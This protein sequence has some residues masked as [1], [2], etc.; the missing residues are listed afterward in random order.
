VTGECGARWAGLVRTVNGHYY[1]TLSKE[2]VE[3][4]TNRS[5]AKS[6][7]CLKKYGYL[8][9]KVNVTHHINNLGVDVLAGT[10]FTIDSDIVKR[11]FYASA[12]AILCNSFNQ[13]DLLRRYLLDSYCLPVLQ[14]NMS[15]IKLTDMQLLELNT[16]WNMI[17]RIIFN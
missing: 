1:C 12:N 2:L 8:I 17:F 13:N 15:V 16:C 11:K 10:Y 9:V 7:R 4:R 3:D 5:R 14:Y 6:K